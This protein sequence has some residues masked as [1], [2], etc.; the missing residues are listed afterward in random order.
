MKVLRQTLPVGGDDFFLTIPIEAALPDQTAS[1]LRAVLSLRKAG[2][3][4][5]ERPGGEENRSRFL[6]GLGLDPAAVNYQKQVHSR[7][8]TVLS[9]EDPAFCRKIE[10]DGIVTAWNDRII[11]VTAA[12]CLPIIMFDRER[13]FFALLHSG[14]KGTGILEDALGVAHNSFGI[15]ARDMAVTIGPG[16]GACCYAVDR[17]RYRAFT[18]AFGASSGRERDGRYYLDL[19]QANLAL[20]EKAGVGYVSLLDNCTCCDPFLGSFRRDGKENF[21]NMIMVLGRF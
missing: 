21:T 7:A 1:G 13:R 15:A 2:H 6:T 17:D 11:A 3:M 14:W 16:I 5:L 8:I 19:R 12:D 18:A 9:A 10:A 4:G 20:C